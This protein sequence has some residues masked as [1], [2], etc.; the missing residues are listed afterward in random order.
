[1]DYKKSG[2]G[3]RG[4]KNAP[5]HQEKN[6]PGGKENPF[7]SKKPKPGP[8][9]EAGNLDRP[10]DG[11]DDFAIDEMKGKSIRGAEGHG[12]HDLGLDDTE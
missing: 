11:A 5:R 7:G 12:K 8:M 6:A 3:G 2:G 1:M 4:A 9:N 10:S